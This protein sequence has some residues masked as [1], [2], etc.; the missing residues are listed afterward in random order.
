RGPATWRHPRDP[1]HGRLR[2]RH[3]KQL[4]RRAAAPGRLLSRRR[5]PGSRA[6]RDAGR[7]HGPG[8]RLMA[9]PEPFRVGLLGHGTVG[10]ALAE[11]LEARA[12]AVRAHSGR[13][14]ELAGVLTRSRGDFEE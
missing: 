6:P 12:V 14:I 9:A 10:A 13:P 7:P 1:G 2:P 11:L 3:G 5:G 4:Q 8:R